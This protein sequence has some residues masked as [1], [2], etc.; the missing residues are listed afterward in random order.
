MKLAATLSIALLFN[1]ASLPLVGQKNTEPTASTTPS[2]VL[3]EY[4]QAV[5]DVAE[6]AMHSVVQ[7][8]VTGFGKPENSDDD[9]DQN[10]LQRQRVIGSGVIVDPSGYIVTNNHVVAGALR[11]RVVVAPTTVELVTGHTQLSNSQTCLRS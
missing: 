9:Q 5:D 4:D 11:I 6:R 1:S 3:R 7:I 2:S 8:E 10:T